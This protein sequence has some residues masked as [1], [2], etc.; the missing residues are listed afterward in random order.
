VEEVAEEGEA[1]EELLKFDPW[2]L[3]PPLLEELASELI[4]D[5]SELRDP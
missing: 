1:P 2:L 4:E 3:L 5:P